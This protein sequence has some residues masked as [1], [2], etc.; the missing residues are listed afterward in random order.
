VERD[1]QPRLIV[2]AAA[3]AGFAAL[4]WPTHALRGRILELLGNPP[5]RGPWILLEHALLDTLLPAVAC[6]LIWHALAKRDLV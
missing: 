5:Y 6:A 2:L 3:A 1:L 4:W